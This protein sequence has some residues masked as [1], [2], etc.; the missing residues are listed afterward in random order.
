MPTTEILASGTSVGNST[1]VTVTAVAPV[2]V[3]LI[4]SGGVIPYIETPLLVQ[5][6]LPDTSWQVT[7]IELSD[8]RTFVL[9]NAPGVYR[10]RRLPLSQSVGVF[11]A[12]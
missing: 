9:L 7:G 8:R 11:S 5:I 3:G 1:T 4:G 10:V 6:Q 2:T 12:T